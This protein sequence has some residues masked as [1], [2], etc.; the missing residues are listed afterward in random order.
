M[1]SIDDINFSLLST[2]QFE[3]LCFDLLMQLGFLIPAWFSEAIVQAMRG[4]PDD[5][6]HNGYLDEFLAFFFGAPLRN[7]AAM[8]PVVGQASVLIANTFN[9]KP[10]DDR[11]STAPAVSMI[12]S[13][14]KAPSSVYRAVVEDGKASRAIRDTLTLV[15]LMTGI[16]LTALGKPLG[17][18]ADVSQGHAAYEPWGHGAG[19]G[20]W[21]SEP[22]Q[23]E[24]EIENLWLCGGHP[25][26]A[27]GEFFNEV[28]AITGRVSARRLS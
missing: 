25:L 4:G 19:A 5:D 17:Y 14:A 22:G 28:G 26:Q 23:Q 6:N 8:V 21:C 1:Q 24:I 15:S 27:F 3:E 2:T 18:A 7:A 9:G 10:Y 20:V 16:P 13:A 11:M 12:E